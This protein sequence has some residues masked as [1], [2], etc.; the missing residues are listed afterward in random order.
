MSEPSLDVF[1][2]LQRMRADHHVG[3]D[4]TVGEGDKF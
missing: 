4:G 3:S 2:Y 1:D